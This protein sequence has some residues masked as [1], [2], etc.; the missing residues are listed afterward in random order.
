M[1]RASLSG[2]SCAETICRS[3]PSTPAELSAFAAELFRSPTCGGTAGAVGGTVD[4]DRNASEVQS[5]LGTL[6]GDVSE[7][8]CH[9]PKHLTEVSVRWTVSLYGYLT[10][11]SIELP[12]LHVSPGV[13]S[14]KGETS[15]SWRR[16]HQCD[17]QR[18][19]VGARGQRPVQRRMKALHR[20]V[21]PADDVLAASH[22]SAVRA[23]AM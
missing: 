11:T 1:D 21:H 12:L 23:V 15:S 3:S 20:E 14:N 7:I 13:Y 17:R 16:G 9:G 10:A 2:L 18:S 4:V 6:D 8:R 22:G 19:K 5:H